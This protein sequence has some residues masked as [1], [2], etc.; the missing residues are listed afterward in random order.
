MSNAVHTGPVEIVVRVPREA[1]RRRVLATLD[2]LSALSYSLTDEWAGPAAAWYM[3]PKVRGSI[4]ILADRTEIEVRFVQ[5]RTLV[6]RLAE[7]GIK[8]PYPGCDADREAIL[9]ASNEG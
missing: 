4:V 7:R 2:D 9:N 1:P 3:E 5:W 6:D 8:L